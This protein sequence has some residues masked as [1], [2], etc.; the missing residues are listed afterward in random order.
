MQV[1]EYLNYSGIPYSTLQH[2]PVYSAQGLAAIEHEPGRYVAKPVIVRI[3]DRYV[4]CVL[5]AHKKV[6]FGALK[7]QLHAR[8]ITLAYEQ[9]FAAFF[10]DCELGAEPPFGHL[11]HLETVMDQDLEK[12]D[13]L[14]FQAGK[15]TEAVRMDMDDYCALVN[16]CVMKLS[17]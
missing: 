6:D 15:H 1:K 14:V 9:E 16:P 12:D 8:S 7:R 17:Y 5:P 13:H 3:D 10:P 2:L 4:M 11:Y